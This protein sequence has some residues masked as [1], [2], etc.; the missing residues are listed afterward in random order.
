MANT[1]VVGAQ[2]ETKQGKMVDYLAQRAGMVVRY[3]GGN[4]AGHTV[5]VGDEVY[6]LHLVPC[7][8]L[9]PD[10]DCVMADG[11][12]IDPAVLIAE[13]EDLQRRGHSM[14]RLRISN[15]AHVIMPYHLLIDQLEEVRKGDSAIGTTGRGRTSVHGQG[16]ANR[17]SDARTGGSRA[18][19]VPSAGPRSR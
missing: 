2:W 3:G 7:G 15:S 12:V 5:M 14:D 11:V 18:I 1:V 4:N 8:I 13:I 10:A 6:K 9:N 17:D 19:R 16:G